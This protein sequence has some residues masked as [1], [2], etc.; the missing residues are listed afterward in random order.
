MPAYHRMAERFFY[1]PVHVKFLP[2]SVGKS[3][4]MCT[5]TRDVYD[6]IVRPCLEE[7]RERKYPK[8]FLCSWKCFHSPPC[9]CLHGPPSPCACLHGPLYNVCVFMAYHHLMY[10]APEL[11]F[12]T[13]ISH[14]PTYFLSPSSG[15]H[16]VYKTGYLWCQLF[17]FLIWGSSLESQPLSVSRFSPF[18]MISS[19]SHVVAKDGISFI[20]WLNGILLCLC[21]PGFATYQLTGI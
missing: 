16:Q 12:P 2:K 4:P 15:N 21:S 10:Y 6:Y 17:I 11:P 1:N 13:N 9:A 5:A 7:A 3:E 20:L 8:S 19:S 18:T 14:L